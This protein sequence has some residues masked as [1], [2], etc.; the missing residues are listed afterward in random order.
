MTMMD[1]ETRIRL[2]RRKAAADAN[3]ATMAGKS[4]AM[5][6][7]ALSSISLPTLTIVTRE[8]VEDEMLARRRADLYR[9]AADQRV[10]GEVEAKH[11]GSPEHLDG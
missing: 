8:R 7:A 4:A 11:T 5:K 1:P 6:A 9:A 2:M 3:P 10:A